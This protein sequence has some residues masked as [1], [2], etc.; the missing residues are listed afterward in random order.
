MANSPVRS[1]SI[2]VIFKEPSPKLALLPG[3]RSRPRRRQG[4]LVEKAYGRLE[5]LIVNCSLKPGRFLTIQDLQ[6]ITGF[7][8]T[9][10]HQAVSML[11]QDT[12]IV[13]RP[14]HGIQIAPIDLARERVL[15]QLRRDI[16]RFVIRLAA[17]RSKPSDRSQILH[18]A[19]ALRERRDELDIDEFN[20]FDRR[21]DRLILSAAGEPFLENTLRPLHTLFRRIGWLHHKYVAGESSLATTVECHL[22][23]MDAV[24]DRDVDQ[25][26]LASDTLTGFV[27]AMFDVLEQQLDPVLLNVSL[28]PLVDI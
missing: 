8:R 13:V 4:N 14:H 18:L 6:D 19:R 5:E 11:S 20:K 28:E 9:P 24:A 27:D 25:A 22:A 10:V 17:E 26:V 15:L 21:I 23:V 7:S 16:E 3:L 2:D 12:L 1:V